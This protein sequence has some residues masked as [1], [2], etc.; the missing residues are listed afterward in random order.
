MHAD[1][2]AHADKTGL[3][4]SI[5][6]QLEPIGRY[7]NPDAKDP[8][9]G[10]DI[11]QYTKNLTSYLAENLEKYADPRGANVFLRV[12]VRLGDDH[13]GHEYRSGHYV[14]DEETK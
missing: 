2:A 4:V 7:Q 9:A 13:A 14:K 8:L 6:A 3:T 11:D 5:I 1:K 12:A 10:T